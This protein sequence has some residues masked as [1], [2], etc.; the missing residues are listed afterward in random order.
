MSK[1]VH[2]L[3]SILLTEMDEFDE[4]MIAAMAADADWAPPPAAV[5]AAADDDDC[6]CCWF[7]SCW[8][9][10]CCDWPPETTA[11]SW[12]ALIVCTP[13]RVCMALSS[14]LCT[15]DQLKGALVRTRS[16]RFIFY[17]LL[18]L[19]LDVY[20]F[21]KRRRCNSV[22][23]FV[24]TLTT[25]T[26]FWRAHALV[27]FCVWVKFVLRSSWQIEIEFRR[28]KKE[29][30]LYLNIKVTFQSRSNN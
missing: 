19:L 8:C 13:D 28:K 25:S 17:F 12:L 18:V 20:C 27:C 22:L 5:A 24:C 1:S 16:E 9:W 30:L 11:L 26:H 4:D 6:I 10:C 15:S 14:C 7:S 21:T 23:L 2:C 29:N 3:T